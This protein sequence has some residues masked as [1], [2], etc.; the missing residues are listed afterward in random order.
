MINC[1]SNM[2]VIIDKVASVVELRT[3]QNPNNN[4][5]PLQTHV[6]NSIVPLGTDW[7][8]IVSILADIMTN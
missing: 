8:T 3:V 7:L 6:R 4:R 5:I 1:D 2:Q